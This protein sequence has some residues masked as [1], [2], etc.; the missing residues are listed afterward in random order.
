MKDSEMEILKQEGQ[1]II[2]EGQMVECLQKIVELAE[3]FRKKNFPENERYSDWASVEGEKLEALQR[4]RKY[5]D[6]KLATIKELAKQM[7]VQI[8]DLCHMPALE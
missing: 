6:D 3:N 7:S 5:G 4:Y 2:E 8:R 1:R